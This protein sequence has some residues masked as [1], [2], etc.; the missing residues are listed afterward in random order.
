MHGQITSANF[1]E[2]LGVKPLLGRTFLPDEDRKPGG[3]PVLVI[4]EALW[5][6]RFGGDPGALGRVVDLNRH[7]FTIVGVVPAPFRGTWASMAYDFWA[8]LSMCREVRNEG[9]LQDR[10]ARGWHNLARLR[11]GTTV[12]QAQAV[13]STFDGRL[14]LTYPNTNRETHHRVVPFAQCPHG[15]QAAMGPTLRLLL[16]VSFGVLLIVAANVANLLLARAVSRQKEI[17]IRLVSGASRLRLVRQLLVESLLL[18]LLGG[19]AG[20]LLAYFMVNLLAVFVP[21]VDLVPNVVLTYSLDGRTLGLTLVL[22]LAT[23]IVF[24]LAP[25]LQASRPQI[26]AALKEGGRSSAS[27]AAH[28]R[29]RQGFVVAEIAL[30]L[31]LL[32]GAGLCLKGMETARGVDLGLNPDRVLLAGLQVGMNGY[33]EE[34]GKVLYRQIRERLA[35]VPGVEEAALASWLPLGLT[36][37]KG[38]GVFVEGYERPA[39]RGPHLRVRDRLAPLLRGAADSL[40]RRPRL[41]RPGRCRRS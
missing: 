10:D 24:G 14:A 11:P 41:H 31:V 25:A 1:F 30:A 18:A 7:A 20:V 13:V 37:C 8:P 22:T 5:R 4:G 6:S 3:N 19:T 32:I 17:A 40:A 34:T 23:G 36:G 2:L 9:N 26:Y 12:E 15:A 35:A 39:R 28:H 21:A 27:A 33:T 38:S 29:L 16:A